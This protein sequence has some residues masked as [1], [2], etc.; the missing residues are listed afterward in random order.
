M[1]F[2]SQC[3]AA[4]E[5]RIP[6]GDS[7]ARFVCPSCQTIH[8]TNPKV[9]VGCLPEWDGRI[10]MCKR[11]IEPRHG[12]WTL[13][14]GFLE[15]H[16]TTIAGAMRET[17]EEA[18]ARVEI[19]SLYALFNLPSV[20]QVYVM[21]RAR[22]L[23]LDFAPGPESLEV[24]LVDESAVPWNEMAFEVITQTLRLY[25]QDYR[26]GTFHTRAG[27]VIRLPGGERVF[28]TR[29]LELP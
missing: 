23:D 11:A 25:W 14:A 22:L 8:Y 20:N 16:E 1:K 17:L 15:D 27:D 3:G 12:L 6:E 4:L 13:P 21:Y 24:K 18:G 5:R 2:C 10:L 7:L 28:E 29:L 26:A 9:V 19:A